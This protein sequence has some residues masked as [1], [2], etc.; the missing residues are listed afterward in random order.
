MFCDER[1]PGSPPM[2][3]TIHHAGNKTGLHNFD[4]ITLIAFS[5]IARRAVLPRPQLMMRP[6]HDPKY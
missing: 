1:G 6:R 3:V 2:R 4:D 5:F